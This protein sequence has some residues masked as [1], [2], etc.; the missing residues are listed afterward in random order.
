VRP[1]A[2]IP[3]AKAYDREEIPMTHRLHLSDLIHQPR[4]LSRFVVDS[5]NHQY[6]T[7]FELVGFVF[8]ATLMIGAYLL[9]AYLV[10][11]EI[12]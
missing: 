3:A 8:A 5:E 7:E 2:A 4:W 10:V 12:F 11:A 6:L 1:A 9:A